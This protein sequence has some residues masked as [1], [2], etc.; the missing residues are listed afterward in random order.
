[1][2]LQDYKDLVARLTYGM[3]KGEAIAKGIC[4]DCSKPV[5]KDGVW[6]I[7]PE[8]VGEYKISALCDACFDKA[9]EEPEEK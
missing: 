5:M 6:I 8:N 4:I 7:N 2:N 9:T 1:M 3:T